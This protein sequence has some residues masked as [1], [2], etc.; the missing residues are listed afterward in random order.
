[1]KHFIKNILPFNNREEMPAWQFAIKKFLAFWLCY[2]VGMFAAEAIVILIHFAC[3]KNPLAGEIFDMQTM[4]LIKYYGYII[5][6]GILLLY[7]KFI[8]KK[9]FSK[10]GITPKI[11][12]YFYGSL[13]AVFLLLLCVSVII[14]IGGFTYLGIFE[15]INFTIILL[16]VGGFV[17]QGAMEE[18]LC[19]GLVFH[20]LKDKTNLSVAIGVST[21]VFIIPHWSSLF[22]DAAVYGV[23]GLINLVLISVIFCM[24]TLKFENIWAACGLHSVWNAILYTILGLNVSGS[25]ESA[26]AIFHIESVGN[27]IRNGG[28][29]GIEASIITT[30]ILFLAA[31]LTFSSALKTVR[32]PLPR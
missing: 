4:T 11:G 23:I 1:M 29:Y 19:R 20:T 9:P 24:L 21:L 7:W 32:S 22:A 15:N 31:V 18:F 27:N 28:M 2:I 14:G 5:F 6:I 12:S 3:G 25:E 13:L 8:E 17:I 30:G 16:F 10:M 26:N